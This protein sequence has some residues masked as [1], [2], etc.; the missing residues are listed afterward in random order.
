MSE[1]WQG[2]AEVAAPVPTAQEQG[3]LD[4]LTK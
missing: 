1:V 2:G 4:A 3:W